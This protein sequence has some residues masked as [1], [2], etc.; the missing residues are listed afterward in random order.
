MLG[1]TPD[2]LEALVD[3][4]N[5]WF[6]TDD[7]QN[8][9]TAFFIATAMP[10]PHFQPTF[11]LLVFYDGDETEGRRIFKPF[12]DIGPVVDLTREGPYVEVVASPYYS[13][14]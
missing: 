8:P 4:F 12:F 11:L 13:T 2:H 9:K 5:K 6:V 1:Y 10:P 3:T 7:G 14:K